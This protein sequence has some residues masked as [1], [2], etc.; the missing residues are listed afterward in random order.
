MGDTFRSW[1]EVQ[2]MVMTQ[3]PQPMKGTLATLIHTSNANK[4]LK[5]RW[6]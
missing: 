1:R 6:N 2:N 5:G 3:N 4:W